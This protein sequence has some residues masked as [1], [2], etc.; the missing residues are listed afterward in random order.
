LAEAGLGRISEKL[1]DLPESELKSG[2][3]LVVTR[4][5]N[6]RFTYLLT[7]TAN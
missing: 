5:I 2:M 3:T 6:P 1:P 7:F 4:Y